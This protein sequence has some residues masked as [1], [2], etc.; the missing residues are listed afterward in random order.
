MKVIFTLSILSFFYFPFSSCINIESDSPKLVQGVLDLSKHNF[1]SKPIV[2]L[3]GEWKFTPGRFDLTEGKDTILITIPDNPHW[4]SYNP[5]QNGLATGFGI[6]SYLVTIVPPKE[7]ITLSLDFNIV[8]SDCRIYQNGILIGSIGDIYGEDDGFDRR[9]I[10]IGL[11]PTN[12]NQV[13]LTILLRNRFYQAGGIRFLP[14][15]GKSETLAAARDKEIFEQS[16]IVGGLFFLGLYQLGVYFT[17]GRIIGSLYFFLFCQIMALQILTTGTRSLFLIVGEHSSELVFR[18]NFFSQ[19]AGAISG[20]YYFYSLT[21]EYISSYIIRGMSGIILIPVLITIFGPIYI[22]SYLHLYVLTALTFLLAIAIYLIVRYIKDK[23]YGYIYLGLSSILLIGC[24]GNDIILSLVHR[25]A[26]MLLSYGLLL[27]VF[28][29]SIFLSKH[30]SNEIITAELNLKAAKYQLVHSEKMSSLGVMVASVAH[31]I[32]SPLSAVIASGAT[33]EERITEHFRL[34][35]ETN[36][37]PSDTFPIF[38]ALI[39]IAINQNDLFPTKETRQTKQD[40]AKQIESLGINDAENKADLFVSLGLREIPADWV[41]ILTGK[42]GDV[43]FLTAER[44][45]SI[46]QGTKSIRIAALRAV[47]IV[48]S[49]KNFTHFDPKAEK[50]KINLSDSIDMVLTIFESAL[51]QGIELVTDFEE[52]P[53]IECYP[54]E[55]NQVWTNMIQNAIQS[56]NGKGFLKIKIGKTENQDKRYVFVSIE[57]SGVGIP[58]DLESKIFDPFFTTKPIGEGTGL[59]LYITKQVVEKHN[60]TIELETKPGRTVFTIFLPWGPE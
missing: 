14:L 48:Q 45:I 6:G 15:L 13:H 60:G 28:F 9:P 37:I 2:P 17:R 26:P 8:F 42:N 35:P 27:F 49:L 36:P 44:I 32:N 56:M 50:Q 38:L 11:L 47:K 58:K 54:D 40:L 51:K 1:Q 43:F 22:I 23:R 46:L 34:L 4:N 20:L 3:I 30:I 33:I 7:P 5:N 41:S 12:D 10:Q 16:L 24:A 53:P 59:G 39:D 18:I 52:I 31:E 29:Q 55:L 57:D 21:R 19:Y 25:T